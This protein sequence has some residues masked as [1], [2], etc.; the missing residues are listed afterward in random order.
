MN[1]LVKA[2]DF[3]ITCRRRTN[4]S[5][6]SHPTGR[7]RIRFC[8]VASK[9]HRSVAGSPFTIPT[10]PIFATCAPKPKRRR[11]LASSCSSRAWRGI[12]DKD[13]PMAQQQSGSGRWVPLPPHVLSEGTRSLS[14]AGGDRRSGEEANHQDLPGLWNQGM[15][16]A[17]PAPMR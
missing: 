10:S 15:C 11:I 13:I 1:S 7:A 9:R 12:G 8:A 16:L 3:L 6:C 17:G 14:P 4:P 5:A 2:Q